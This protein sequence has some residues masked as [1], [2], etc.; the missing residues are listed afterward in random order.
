MARK[1]L[2]IA[3]IAA[4]VATG[5]AVAQPAPGGANL[6][7]GFTQ[8]FISPCG[9]PYRGRPGEPYPVALW[10]KQADLNH[11]GVIDKAEFR[12]DHAG[13]FDALDSDGNGVLDGTEI[14]FYE[15]KVVPDVFGREEPR[16]GALSPAGRDGAQ[17]I[18]AQI[19]GQP[20]G[21]LSGIPSGAGA[22][23]PI[24]GL[25]SQRRQ[26]EVME[27]A[28]AYTLLREAEPLMAADTDLDGRIT[29][30]EFLAA[31][32]RRFARLDKRGDG[33]LT[34]DELPR[35]VA[36]VELEDRARRAKR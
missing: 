9:E 10:F 18:L 36:Q 19:N 30:E 24:S 3:G 16:L 33:K 34:L 12:A 20:H 5:L 17:L 1:T 27:G 13:F 32:D 22:Q 28:A 11:D 2:A 7:G 8:L 26:H 4:S 23:G 21:D 25:N 6:V 15:H 35:T 14:G 31:A 29:K